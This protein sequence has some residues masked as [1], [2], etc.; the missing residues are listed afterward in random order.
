[1]PFLFASTPALW[2]GFA[3]AA[4]GAAAAPFVKNEER[5]FLSTAAVTASLGFSG[6]YAAASLWDARDAVKSAARSSGS[7]LFGGKDALFRMRDAAEAGM[8]ESRVFSAAAANS[9]ADLAMEYYSSS[10]AGSAL[11]APDPEEL[12][13]KVFSALEKLQELQKEGADKDAAAAAFDFAVSRAR[14]RAMPEELFAANP[15]LASFETVGKARLASGMSSVVEKDLAGL[16]GRNDAL[17]EYLRVLSSG[18]NPFVEKPSRLQGVYAPSEFANYVTTGEGYSFQKE[19]IVRTR[20]GFSEE[21]IRAVASRLPHLEEALG[22]AGR[23]GFFESAF[24][25]SA[26]GG[27]PLGIEFFR[28]GKKLRVSFVDPQT[29][30]VRTGEDFH[31]AGAARKILH[32]ENIT[33]LDVYM[34]QRLSEDWSDLQKTAERAV[35]WRASHVD[36]EFMQALTGVLDESSTVYSELHPEAVWFRKHQV[37]PTELPEFDGKRMSEMS[38]EDR[39]KWL[40]RLGDRIRKYGSE[41]SFRKM[42]LEEP[43]I[44]QIR[45]GQLSSMKKQDPVF[46]SFSKPYR[47]RPETVSPF[48]RPRI[49]TSVIDEIFRGELPAARFRFAGVSPQ[50]VAFFGNLPDSPEKLSD[51]KLRQLLLRN[52]AEDIRVDFPDLPETEV[53]ARAEEAFRRLEQKWM[54]H[55]WMMQEA[56]ALGTLGE[57]EFL[58]SNHVSFVEAGERL[59]YNLQAVS[60]KIFDGGGPVEFARG[61]LLGYD[62]EG[63]PVFL[64]AQKARMVYVT[65]VGEK[66]QFRLTLETS[67]PLGGGAKMDVLGKK[68]LMTF[69]SSVDTYAAGISSLNIIHEATGRGAPYTYSSDILVNQAYFSSDLGEEALQALLEASQLVAESAPEAAPVKQWMQEME[70]LSFRM[71][72]LGKGRFQMFEDSAAVAALSDAARA[73]RLEKIL[74]S[75]RAMLSAMEKEVP[76]L[77]DEWARAYASVL[78]SG[79]RMPLEQFFRMYYQPGTAAVWDS[80]LRE[81]PRQVRL[82]YDVL[83]EL[84]RAGEFEAVAELLSRARPEGG[85][86]AETYR[87]LQ[88]LAFGDW[89]PPQG[90]S[91]IQLS[92]IGPLPKT[93]DPGALAGT[94]FDPEFAATKKNYWIDLGEEVEFE[95]AGRKMKTRYIPALGTSSYLGG[96]N[97]Y[98]AGQKAL[99]EYQSVLARTVETLQSG[100]GEQAAPVLERYFRETL[101]ILVGKEGLWRQPLLSTGSIVGAIQ[102][103]PSRS[104]VEM[105]GEMIRNPFEVVI[106]RSF[107]DELPERVAGELRKGGVAYAVAFRHPVS[108]TP[109]VRVRLAGKDDFAG[110]R[111]MGIDEGLRSLLQADSD[112]DFLNLVFLQS[113][114]AINRARQAIGTG[115][116]PKSS[117]SGKVAA[118]VGEQIPAAKGSPAAASLADAVL[119]E[120]AKL[121]GQWKQVRAAQL[122]QGTAEDVTRMTAGFTRAQREAGLYDDVVKVLQAAKK[123]PGQLSPERMQSLVDR[124]AGDTIG[125]YSNVLSTLYLSLENH[126]AVPVAGLDQTILH[127]LLWNIRQV[128]ISAAKGKMGLGSQPMQLYWQMLSALRAPDKEAGARLFTEAVQRISEGTKFETVVNSQRDL[129]DIAAIF[130]IREIGEPGKRRALKVG[131]RFNLFAEVVRSEKGRKLLHDFVVHRNRESDTVANL[132]TRGEMTAEEAMGYLRRMSKSPFGAATYLRAGVAGEKAAASRSAAAIG[133]VNASLSEAASEIGGRFRRALPVLAAAGGVAALAGIFGVRM[134][135]AS[136]EFRPPSADSVPGEEFRGMDGHRPPARRRAKPAAPERVMAAPHGYDNIVEIETEAGSR[137]DW[138][139][140]REALDRNSARN[141]VSVEFSRR[142]GPGDAGKLRRRERLRA[143]LEREVSF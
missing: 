57:T 53:S 56:R 81:M 25:V 92:D 77:G 88:D 109:Y 139:A 70:Q 95:V 118:T 20:F 110:P 126:P 36:D 68:G 34:L 76:A 44:E 96:A 105:G 2:A 40:R 128:P 91:V 99:G 104:W 46:R 28:G 101:P 49:M 79:R 143:E 120:A 121:S 73:E 74:A 111:V 29:G 42:V 116:V 86:A 16:A 39:E 107:L 1:M 132:L 90:A 10:Q 8:A 26:P 52:L 102:S 64:E 122:L 37:V 45:L 6:F 54:Q 11:K 47:I 85:S 115:P 31:L 134:K 62:M 14:A 65:P 27:S 82:T 112:R 124:L 113:E 140:F 17:A 89:K 103:R 43:E 22:Q 69:G 12:K 80:T 94:L 18:L 125:A 98:G 63:R 137:S 5:G 32:G 30:M 19:N 84:H 58:A 133:A 23:S 142:M 24:L 55:P 33:Q 129:D 123:A 108:A 61:D 50:L 93:R 127:S 106:S 119:P 135:P 21:E 35:V 117:V 71:K 15:E 7:V 131:D 97:R 87:F 138:E 114:D 51:P 83:S 130:G 100:M 67:T 3:G 48:Y 136:A 60:K 9:M 75:S 59:S 38:L 66:K 72:D 41:S 141:G 78:E 4:A 13:K